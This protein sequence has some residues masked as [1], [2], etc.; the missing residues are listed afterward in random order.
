MSAIGF[1]SGSVNG[2]AHLDN[3]PAGRVINLQTSAD[4]GIA[5]WNPADNAYGAAETIAAPG[6]EVSCPHHRAKLTGIANVTITL[7]E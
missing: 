2:D 4:V 3:L 7:G 5:F 6:D 1:F